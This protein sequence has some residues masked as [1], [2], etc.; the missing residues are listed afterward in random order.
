MNVTLKLC[1]PGLPV[2]INLMGAPDEDPNKIS[3]PA[4]AGTQ[5]MSSTA[6]AT[7]ARK[8][9][10]M[11]NSFTARQSRDN[12]RDY[13]KTLLHDNYMNIKF[14]SRLWILV[15]KSDT[16]REKHVERQNSRLD[17]IEFAGF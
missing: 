15:N 11:F 5:P 4:N 12:L 2:P 6:G 7:N 8:N 17:S 9:L 16:Y 3:L 13:S 10:F 1:A 14:A